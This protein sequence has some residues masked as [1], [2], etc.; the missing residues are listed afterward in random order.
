MGSYSMSQPNWLWS[1]VSYLVDSDVNGQRRLSCH[2]RRNHI[3]SQRV[4][5]KEHESSADLDFCVTDRQLPF[6]GS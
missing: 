3:E 4:A 5:H 2:P 6:G 1:H